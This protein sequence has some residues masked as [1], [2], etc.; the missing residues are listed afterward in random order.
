M[1]KN[2]FLYKNNNT[3][4]MIYKFDRPISTCAIL[5]FTRIRME[6]YDMTY[7]TQ[8]RPSSVLRFDSEKHNQ[9]R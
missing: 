5:N 8:V 1:L 4:L 6:D 7:I 3:K 9:K 2:K